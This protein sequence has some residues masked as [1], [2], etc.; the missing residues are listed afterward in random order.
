MAWPAYATPNVSTLIAACQN[1]Y[2][3]IVLVIDNSAWSSR[4]AESLDGAR[5]FLRAAGYCNGQSN[6]RVAIVFFNIDYAT[7]MTFNDAQGW[8][9][10]DNVLSNSFVSREYGNNPQLAFNSVYR[11]LLNDRRD[12]A[13]FVVAFFTSFGLYG[14]KVA[15]LEEADNLKNSGVEIFAFG[16]EYA[17]VDELGLIQSNNAASMKGE[18]VNDMVSRVE[19]TLFSSRVIERPGTVDPPGPP[20]TPE[21]PGNLLFTLIYDYNSL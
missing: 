10:A 20:G 7:P 15:M 16:Y 6:I 8:S 4:Y 17:M 5:E 14:N 18:S 21:P 12:G 9:Y 13:K 1:Q 3:E 19:S 11:E 2:L